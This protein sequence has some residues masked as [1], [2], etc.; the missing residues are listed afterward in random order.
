MIELPQTEPDPARVQVVHNAAD[1]AAEVV[2][3]YVDINTDI[4]KVEDFAFR[5]A[6][7]FLD[8]PAEEEITIVVAPGSSES[9][10]EGIASFPVTLEEG[11]SYH[12]VANGVLNPDDFA[13]NPEGLDIAFTLFTAADA[14]EAA[15]DGESVDLRVLHGATDA[16]NVGVNA[17]GGAVIPGFSYGDFAGY[18]SVPADF[19]QLDITP[20][21]EPETV[22]LSFDADLSGLGGGAALVIASGF[23]DPS[24]NQDG[25]AFALIAVLPDGTVIELP[26]TEPE[27]PGPFQLLNGDGD[28][29]IADLQDGDVIDLADYPLDR[30][31]IQVV[32]DA[33]T[34]GRVDFE[35]SGPLSVVRAEIFAP[36]FLF[37][38]L[39]VARRL[40]PGSY[41]L[42]ATPNTQRGSGGE[43]LEPLSISFEVVN[44][45]SFASIQLVSRND[46]VLDEVFEDG[47][48]INLSDFPG[49][50]FNVL[51]ETDPAVA[52]SVVFEMTGPLSRTGVENAAPYFLFGPDNFGRELPVGNY[53][54]TV[55]PYNEIGG[56]GFAGETVTINF[57]V[58]EDDMPFRTLPQNGQL[59]ADVTAGALNVAV[60]PNP[61]N[62]RAYLRLAG[63]AT[64]TIHARIID[65]QG[66]VV[67]EMVIVKEDADFDVPVDVS[68]LNAGMYFIQLFLDDHQSSTRLIITK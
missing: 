28:I 57:E 23:L 7:P 54:L 51:A 65:Q 42:T 36:Y 34:I 59:Q 1:P 35:L 16:P 26:Q 2:D 11:Q 15:E 52:G 4:V 31:N 41:T 48:V 21:G 63:E 29:L 44:S 32:P 27:Q 39:P 10:E 53:T 25:A 12:V 22:L 40:P 60:A 3:I 8:L 38:D 68:N 14:R 45:A 46:E 58:I 18:L 66:A 47:D 6:T 56:N 24:A 49:V 62:S 33:E 43:A 17:N 50:R 9:I 64:G 30:F 5:S 37:S 61:T 20:G 13:P 19:Y 55:T 67:K